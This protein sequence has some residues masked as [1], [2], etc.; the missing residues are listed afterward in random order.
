MLHDLQNRDII[1]FKGVFGD[2]TGYFFILRNPPLEE[3][4]IAL[5]RTIWT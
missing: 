1:T 2:F 4:E 5:E 3:Q